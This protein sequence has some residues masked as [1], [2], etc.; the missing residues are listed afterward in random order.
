MCPLCFQDQETVEHS[1]LLCPWTRPIWFESQVQC[2]PTTHTV[3]SFGN[4][5]LSKRDNMRNAMDG[6]FCNAA[7]TGATTAAFRDSNGRVLL[8]TATKVKAISTLTVKVLSIR[9]ALIATKNLNVQNLIIE[10]DNQ[11]LRQA[12]KSIARIAEILPILDDIRKLIQH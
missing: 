3:T 8:T 10:T 6:A 5:F 9:Q 4:W 2:T 12:L 1:L 11:Q 7:S